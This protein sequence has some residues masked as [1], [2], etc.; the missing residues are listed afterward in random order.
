MFLPLTKPEMKKILGLMLKKVHKTLAKSDLKMELSER[1]MDLMTELG[2]DPQFGA[3]PMKRVIQRELLNSMSKELLAGSYNAGDTVYID[4]DGKN[5]IFSNEGFKGSD[6]PIPESAKP[7]KKP[8]E[9]TEKIAEDLEKA[10]KD[11]QDAVDEVK[12][13]PKNGVE[14]EGKD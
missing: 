5:L 9:S 3:R 4:A 8:K 11:V 14:K 2:Y 12:G 6:A 10:A 13:E 7:K 1:A